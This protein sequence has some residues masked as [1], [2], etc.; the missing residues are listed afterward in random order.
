MQHA[1]SEHDSLCIAGS[2]TYCIRYCYRSFL[3]WKRRV[4]RAGGA[5]TEIGYSKEYRVL[6]YEKFSCSEC[7]IVALLH[8]CL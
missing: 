6:P 3:A 4:K 2:T 1:G 7:R 5:P 8:C